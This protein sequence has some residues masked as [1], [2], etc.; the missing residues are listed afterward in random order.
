MKSGLAQ[1]RSVFEVFARRIP[2]G[3]AYGVVAGMN[4]LIEA[5]AN[6]QFDQ[7]SLDYL[8]TTGVL[9]Q[10]GMR[11]WLADYRF[12][13]NITGYADG[14]IFFPYSPVLTVEGTYAECVVLETIILSILNHDCAVAGAAA[15]VT[16]SA[17]GKALID[18]GSRRTDPDAAVAA[19][20]AA[21]IGGFDTTSNLEAGRRYAIPT[22]GT[23]AHAFML[24]HDSER[25]AFLAQLNALGPQSTYLVDTF[26]IQRG[27]TNAVQVVGTGIGGVRIDSGDLA[28]ESEKARRL[29]DDLGA[30]DAKIVVSSDLDEFRVY[31][32]EKAD[33]PIDAYLVGTSLVTGSGHPTA[34]MVYKLVSIATGDSADSDLRAVG[35]LS[36]GKRTIGGRKD[37][38]RTVDE[39]GYWNNEVL[40]IDPAQGVENAY[41]PQQVMVEAGRVLYSPDLAAAKARCAKSR[42]LLR[43]ELR[44][45]Y[46]QQSP[47]I[48][49]TWIGIETDSQGNPTVETL[50]PKPSGAAKGSIETVLI[51]G[52]TTAGSRTPTAAPTAAPG[53]EAAP[54][55]A[56]PTRPGVTPTASPTPTV[57]PTAAISGLRQDQIDT[58]T[59]SSVAAHT[60]INEG[61]HDKSAI[62]DSAVSTAIQSEFDVIE[63]NEDFSDADP[64]TYE[65]ASVRA[66]IIVDVQNDFCEGGSLAVAGGSNLA[67]EITQILKRNEDSREFDYICATRDWHIDPG[68]H[69]E[70][71]PVHCKVGTDGCQIHPN[72]VLTESVAI[73]NKGEYE[74]AYSG[75]EAKHHQSG[76]LL[77]D[78]LT[79]HGVTDV[80]IVGIATDYCVKAS[81][82]DAAKA[83]FKTVVRLD[84][85]RGIAAETVLQAIDE[86]KRAGVV[87]G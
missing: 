23:T 84:Q 64:V 66:L 37:V 8:E 58:A 42:S 83:G 15:R 4:R 86:M 45:P 9:D 69:F 14:E 81:A 59:I 40:T 53:A 78:W 38:D 21:H 12:S 29:L 25:A 33:A 39:D 56:T 30:T 41:K 20:R 27:V 61:A 79:E 74:A 49:T 32:L 76:Q 11:E 19:A 47:A 3:R 44:T 43:P 48:A 85:C 82:V 70:V 10:P 55:A 73:F 18:G 26:D 62:D 52:T 72:L 24:A 1:R 54:T 34:S 16:D 22:G 75:F 51:S 87:F 5:V 77:G 7:S 46:P 63:E 67:S 31:E 57:T 35:K 50:A 13:G 17:N 80:E 2:A 60:A 65:P 71:W 28:V 68:E 36:P 6:F